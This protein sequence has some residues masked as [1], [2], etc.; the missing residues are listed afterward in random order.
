VLISG[1][2][3]L[4]YLLNQWTAASAWE[5]AQMTG[6]VLY[7]FCIIGTMVGR[8]PTLYQRYRCAGRRSGG[9][10]GRG[11]VLGRRLRTCCGAAGTLLRPSP[12]PLY[13]SPQHCQSTMRF[14]LHPGLQGVDLCNHAATWLL[15]PCDQKLPG[16]ASPQYRVPLLPP[17]EIL[18]T[19]LNVAVMSAV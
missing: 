15:Y 11:D 13:H 12:Q 17:G 6:V 18:C 7:H 16:D 1:A 14:S 3:Q 10:V 9:R 8:Q 19:D 2:A 5:N 4:A